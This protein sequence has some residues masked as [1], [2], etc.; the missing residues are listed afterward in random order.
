[1]GLENNYYG[2]CCMWCDCLL[3]R[4]F[5]KKATFDFKAL[6]ELMDVYHS[7]K[8]MGKKKKPHRNKFDDLRMVWVQ[9]RLTAYVSKLTFVLFYHSLISRF[10][11]V[12]MAQ[13]YT[14]CLSTMLNQKFE[15][16]DY[17]VLDPRSC[18][19]TTVLTSLGR[20]GRRGLC[21]AD[22]PVQTPSYTKNFQSHL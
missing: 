8:S 22:F 2:V 16:E 12:I 6:Q 1:M 15:V 20:I 17:D 4:L 10:V 7:L 5:Q 9:N 18:Q 21:A 3:S 19:V 13:F 11:V 14:A